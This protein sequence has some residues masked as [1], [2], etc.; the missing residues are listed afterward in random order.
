[1]PPTTDT[2]TDLSRF[3]SRELAEAGLLLTA[4]AN[5]P[6]AV[7]LGDHATLMFNPNSGFVFLT[8]EDTYKAYLL[9]ERDELEEWATCGTCGAEDFASALPLS[10]E[11]DCPTCRAR[12]TI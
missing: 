9:N 11:G 10:D 1:M 6:A 8:D 2:L 7:D 5:A 12:P 3:G 4:W